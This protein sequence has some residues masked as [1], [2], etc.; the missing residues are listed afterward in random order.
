MALIKGYSPVL[1]S[2]RN[3]MRCAYLDAKHRSSPW[4]ARVPTK[5][6]I[7]DDPSRMSKEG[8]MKLNVLVVKPYLSD[9]YEWFADVLR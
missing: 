3:I 4:Y 9:G 8:L 2:L 1:T 7:A 5:S 6:N